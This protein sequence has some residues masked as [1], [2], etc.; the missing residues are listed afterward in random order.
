MD[1]TNIG[2]QDPVAL[3]RTMLRLAHKFSEPGRVVEPDDLAHDAF[4]AVLERADR[5]DQARGRF[6]TYNYVRIRGAMIDS[7][8]A[9]HHENRHRPDDTRKPL[10]LVDDL[11]QRIRDPRPPATCATLCAEVLALA[12]RL[13]R[14]QAQIIRRVYG[15]GWQFAEVAD[16]LGV[17]PP[18]VSQ[19][20]KAAIVTLRKLSHGRAAA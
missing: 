10:P 9:W 6:Y 18:R 3:R 17:T 15:E 13:P 5:F 4:V 12:E 2:D 20:H 11:V 14:Q 8:R 16:E 19:L 1:Q 7:L